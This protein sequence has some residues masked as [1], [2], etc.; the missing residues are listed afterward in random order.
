MKVT[1]KAALGSLKE[2][3]VVLDLREGAKVRDAI[4]LLGER[5]GKE[6]ESFLLTET[7]KLEND[8]LVIRN[9]VFVADANDR[10]SDGDM[11]FISVMLPGG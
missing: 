9:Q 8:V 3:E 7:G 2:S 5:H 4:R 6:V 10:L 1:V 11:V